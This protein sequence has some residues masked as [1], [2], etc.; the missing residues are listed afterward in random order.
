MPQTLPVLCKRSDCTFQL[1]F[2]LQKCPDFNLFLA[3]K[4][5]LDDCSAGLIVFAKDATLHYCS[6]I[7]SRVL[8]GTMLCL[9]LCKLLRL[10][11]ELGKMHFSAL[12]ALRKTEVVIG[13]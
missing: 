1:K 9:A 8:F 10:H 13:M 2:G 5:E 12:K 11:I 4:G 7:Q 3:L 6:L